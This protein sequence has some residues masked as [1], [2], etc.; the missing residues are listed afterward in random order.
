MSVFI[1][2]VLVIAGLIVLLLLIA[3][4]ISKDYSVKSDILIKKPKQV[5]FDYIKLLKNQAYYSKW[6]MADPNARMETKGTDGTVGFTSSWDSDNKQVG[7]G[8]QEIVS[9]KEGERMDV[10][11]H[12]I[13]PFENDARAYFVTD[14]TGTGE[15]KLTW[16]MLGQNPWPMNLMNLFIPGLLQ[17]DMSES[18]GNLKVIL[19]K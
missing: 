14:T 9:L 10:G 11:L 8:S 18:L 17:K 2:V 4:V 19:E 5:V 7:K 15:T 6:V 16:V 12:F 13:R 1:T 3:A